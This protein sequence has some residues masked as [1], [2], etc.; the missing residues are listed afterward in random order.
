M[1]DRSVNLQSTVENPVV[2]IAKTFIL[3]TLAWIVV[4]LLG[5]F[6]FSMTIL[7]PLK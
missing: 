5:Y 6:G 2:N 1:E 3:K 7:K 4:Y